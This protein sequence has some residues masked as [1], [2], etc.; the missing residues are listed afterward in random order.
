MKRGSEENNG[1][2]RVRVKLMKKNR[3][4]IKGDEENCG[5][6]LYSRLNQYVEKPNGI[7]Y[8]AKT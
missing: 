3:V 7:G 5:R 6:N 1:I 4:K 8:A 2:K